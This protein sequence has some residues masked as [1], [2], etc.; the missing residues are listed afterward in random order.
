MSTDQEYDTQA[1][2]IDEM[3]ADDLDADNF[4]PNFQLPTTVGQGPH[5]A[6]QTSPPMTSSATSDSGGGVNMIDPFDP[7]LDADPFGLT[8]SMHFPNPYP[9]PPTQPRR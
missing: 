9:F 3:D 1:D 8:A 6:M 4:I 5:M 2:M 7:M